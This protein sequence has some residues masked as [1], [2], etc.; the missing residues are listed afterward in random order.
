[1]QLPDEPSVEIRPKKKPA[2][3]KGTIKLVANRVHALE[4]ITDVQ[5]DLPF[6]G[7][8]DQSEEILELI[9]DLRR[10]RSSAAV[11][12]DMVSQVGA[13]AFLRAWPPVRHPQEPPDG[14]SSGEEGDGVDPDQERASTSSRVWRVTALPDG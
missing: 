5:N 7:L 2:M 12:E 1:V 6:P 8:F 9:V 14:D 3:P 11:S 10:T 13:R 4:V